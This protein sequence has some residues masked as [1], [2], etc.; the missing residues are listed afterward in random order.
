M[1][2]FY[3]KSLFGLVHGII[4]KMRFLAQTKVEG[5][6]KGKGRGR[7]RKRRERRKGKGNWKWSF[8]RN[9]KNRKRPSRESNPGPQQTRLMP[10]SHRDKRYHQPVCL[11]FYPLLKFLLKRIFWWKPCE[12]I[13]WQSWYKM[14][15]KLLSC[16]GFLYK[17]VHK[18]ARFSVFI[19]TIFFSF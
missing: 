5:R 3:W 18:T 14:P 7:E 12:K 1:W 6:R 13:Q 15:S 2:D 19:F 8:G 16:I 17:V 9:G 11:K 4:A 10:L